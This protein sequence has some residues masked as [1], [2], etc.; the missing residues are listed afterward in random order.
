MAKLIVFLS[1][2][3]IPVTAADLAIECEVQKASEA[4]VREFLEKCV[5]GLGQIA[6]FSMLDSIKEEADDRCNTSSD[7][8]KEYLKHAPCL[9]TAGPTVHKC[10]QDL[11][12]GLDSATRLEK[13]KIEGACCKFNVFKECHSNAAHKNCDADG[14]KFSDAWLQKF[15]G[16]LLSGLCRPFKQDDC[17]NLHFTDAKGSIVPKSALPSLL[18]LSKSLG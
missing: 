12:T 10:L 1:K 3:T 6:G 9:N 2:E 14:I 15:A 8:H 11:A 7:Y 18:K 5:E 4:C 13:R 16:G 17:G